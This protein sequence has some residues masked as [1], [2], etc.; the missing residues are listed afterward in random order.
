MDRWMDVCKLL[1]QAKKIGQII[2]KF[3]TVIVY[4]QDSILFSRYYQ[5]FETYAGETASRS[6]SII[7]TLITS[8]ELKHLICYSRAIAEA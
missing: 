3:G 6:E 4:K 8:N 5:G 1:F 2:K 7:Q